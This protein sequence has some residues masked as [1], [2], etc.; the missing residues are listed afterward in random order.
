M[1]ATL[2]REDVRYL[3]TSFAS[4]IELDQVLVDRLPTERFHFHYSGGMWRNWRQ[5]HLDYITL[6]LRTVD[7]IPLVLLQGLTG[8]SI[9]YEPAVIRE[10]SLNIFGETVMGG[11]PY[12]DL[13]D[14]SLFFGE[15][16]RT[17]SQKPPGN[18]PKGGAHDLMKRWLFIT[19]PLRIAE[20]SECGYGPPVGFLN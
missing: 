14:A 4:A 10:A 5:G 1:F 19:D 6:L 3:L 8:I 11:F 20:D 16:I 15:L 7:D 9:G 2:T 13:D 12:E 17:V 18:S